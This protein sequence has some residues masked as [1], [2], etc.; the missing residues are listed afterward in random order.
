MLPACSGICEP[1][2]ESHLM[3]QPRSASFVLMVSLL[4]IA[5]NSLGDAAAQ[6]KSPPVK[7]HVDSIL[8]TY[9]QDIVSSSNG[10]PTVRMDHR[11]T[12][13]GIA[14]RLLLMFDYNDYQLKLAQVEDSD[15]GEAVAFN[16][17]G[18]HILHIAPLAI[19]GDALA[20]PMKMISGGMLLLV[21]EHRPNQFYITAI[22]ADSPLLPHVSHVRI[23]P[24][25][26]HE[27]DA[28]VRA[29]PALIPAQ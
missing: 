10:A 9:S 2:R 28:P 8:A 13:S 26:A 29:F 25:A 5:A 11:L 19:I 3:P 17:P 16:L 20:M 22:S 14:D 6:D 24:G 12:S 27:P 15:F 4:L 21:D 1:R 23:S 18:G 7:I